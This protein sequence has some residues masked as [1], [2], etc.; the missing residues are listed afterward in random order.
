MKGL[1][2]GTVTSFKKQRGFG[3]IK[4]DKSHLGDKV[5]CHWKTI[6]STEKWPTLVEGMRVAF[7]A[8]KDEKKAGGWK[9]T[10]VYTEDGKEISIKDT[11]ILLENGEKYR[12]ECTSW[13]KVKGEGLIKAHEEGPWLK[14]RLRVLR[15]D[16]DPDAGATSLRKGQQVQFQVTKDKS[17]YRAV[18][19]VLPGVS[20]AMKAIKS[21]GKTEKVAEKQAEKKDLK[22]GAQKRPLEKANKDTN[23]LAPKKINLGVKKQMKRSQLQS[24]TYGGMEVSVE[25]VIEVGVLLKSSW[26]GSLIGK[27]GATI[28][29]IKKL[30]DA[31]MQFGNDEIQ[32]AGA[33]FK[34]FAISGTMNQVADACK[35]VA[36]KVG[37]A[38]QT[39]EY[40]IVFLVPDDYC[41]MFV[42]KKGSTINEIRGEVDLRVRVVLSQ[43]PLMLP[44]ASMVNV[45]TVFGPRE[46]VKD[47]IERTVAVLGGISARIKKQM[48]EPP[49]MPQWE[50][51]RF[52]GNRFGGNRFGGYRGNFQD[53]GASKAGRL[54]ND[55]VPG[56]SRVS[57]DW[58]R[59]PPGG[60]RRQWK[61]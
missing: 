11:V 48:M 34:V 16:I 29:E 6:K 27:K 55:W 25:D 58:G 37:E 56:A 5:S 12:G 32:Y 41:G 10:E 50:G 57:L 43:T 51:D 60:G 44:G 3:Y 19:V 54:A 28:R 13:N 33:S 7:K 45:C 36:V 17:V 30:S 23:G 39:L 49:Q 20:K 61:A 1:L 52:G 14:K 15:S 53:I 31:N 35:V 9:T 24:G 40:K 46:N 21:V 18:N 47:A 26:V 38:A 22:K 4:P 2:L 8:G 59:G 42:G